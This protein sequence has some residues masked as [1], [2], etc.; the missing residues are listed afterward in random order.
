MIYVEN[1]RQALVKIDPANEAAYTAN[2]AAYTAK[3]KALDEPVRRKLADIPEAQR[4][5]VTQ[6]G[7]V[8]LSLR[9]TT[10]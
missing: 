2:A 7:R 10:G 3:I 5:L 4:W 1:I 9:A 8:F 6:R